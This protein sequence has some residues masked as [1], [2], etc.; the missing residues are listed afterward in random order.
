MF[1]DE[2][3]N[4][5][6]IEGAYKKIKSLYF[7]S[8]DKLFER[9]KIGLF[10][11]NQT[12]M[13]KIFKKLALLL[14]NP[15]KTSNQKYIKNL[16]DKIDFYAFPKNFDPKQNHILTISNK[17]IETELTKIN[18]L[19]NMPIELMLLDC[20]WTLLI[21]KISYDNCSVSDS[22]YA[23]NFNQLYYEDS[24]DFFSNRFFKPYF[25]QYSNWR[26][27]ALKKIDDCYEKG[28]NTTLI[29]LDIK[30][31]F[32]SVNFNFNRLPE[33][34]N[35]D[36]RLADFSFLTEII[37]KIYFKYTKLL[38]GFRTNIIANTD[39][40]ECIF[41]FQLASSCFLANL[42][43]QNFDKQIN[44]ND[45]TLYYGRYVD[46]IVIVM[47]NDSDD[48]A[49]TAEDI[50]NNLL[51]QSE[52]LNMQGNGIYGINNTDLKINAEKMKVFNFYHDEP[53]VL[54]E[55]M[56]AKLLVNVSTVN[57]FD[58]SIDL[59]GFNGT[60]YY[61]EKDNNFS[62]FKDFNLLVS[63]NYSATQYI[64]KLIN[65][66][67]N[68]IDPFK[69]ENESILEFYSG[70]RCLEYRG[71]WALIFYLGVI[72]NDGQYIR[73]F[74]E[75]VVTQINKLTKVKLQDIYSTKK[76]DI[77]F[78][79]KESLNYEL[80]IAM[81]IA[82]SLNIPII[83]KDEIKKIALT[84][85]KANLFNHHLVSYPLI[86]YTTNSNSEEYS[87]IESDI[88]I[89]A[90]QKL[91][92]DERKLKYS[93]RFIHFEDLNLFSF[94]QNYENGGNLFLGKINNIFEEF[95]KINSIDTEFRI[96]QNR[97]SSGIE[98]IEYHAMENIKNMTVGVA[99]IL[100]KEEDCLNVVKNPKLLLTV[101]NKK[102]LFSLLKTA[103]DNNAKI[104]VMPE[105]YL[106][107]AWLG[108][109][110]NFA[111]RAGFTIVLG[112]QYIKKGKRV[113]NFI[114]N[115]QPFYTSSKIKYR[116]L[117]THIREKYDYAP[118]EIDA[119]KP[120]KVINSP[121]DW[122]TIYNLCN[123]CTYSNRLCYEFTNIS[124]RALLK[125][126]I[127]LILVPEFNKDTNYFS[128]IIESTVRD[129][130]CFI[131][132]SNTSQYGD[133]CITGPYKTEQKNILKIKGAKNNNMLVDDI[134]IYEL[135][136]FKQLIA[137]GYS[138]DMANKRCGSKLKCE[139][140]KPPARFFN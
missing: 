64:N 54:L 32:Y 104:V 5:N 67:K 43:L 2:N 99:S 96:E 16:I 65:I 12:N 71:S 123:Q 4:Y 18:F 132:Q 74:Y 115:I 46:D 38:K 113:Y 51:I 1:T 30:S 98:T 49:I 88:N 133:S 78:K 62:K 28:Q 13:E 131:A 134:Q 20:L 56:K 89:I 120:Y 29:S 47:R 92:L 140:K 19:I 124:S 34:F 94:L 24:I 8:K 111:R 83:K 122:I 69:N 42:Y 7:Y 75:Q 31:Y 102:D 22:N 105:L 128:N 121:R 48:K 95:K 117:F 110:S 137:K 101:E 9:H 87:L 59:A 93:P 81:A 10:E 23:C 41:P 138:V 85:K 91:I 37:A 44:E 77:L 112:L 119:L 35:N 136:K 108:D 114:A 84:I 107:I 6:I 33:Y 90:K 26:N 53:K 82:L 80:N 57:F 17:I 36:N 58:D 68:I 129:N 11:E 126:K 60:V 139:F 103:E 50:I 15:I 130:M 125:N 25:K 39:E 66:N 135:I 45:K 55:N 73:S 86:N 52:I 14:K 21:G 61:Q 72:Q 70:S 127:D 3:K 76:D 106:P 118:I 116:N 109:V 63:D 100:L 97:H 27:K 40:E 79:I